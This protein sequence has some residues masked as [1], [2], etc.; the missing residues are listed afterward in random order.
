MYLVL[1]LCFF[2]SETGYLGVIVLGDS[3]AGHFRIP[4]QWL[5]SSMLDGEV[6]KNVEFIVAN[7]MDWPQ[8]SLYTAYLNES[9]SVSQLN[10]AQAV[11]FGRHSLGK[12]A[13]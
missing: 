9:R 7:E 8:L 3:V 13:A 12:N 10:V 5:T 4:P 11:Q 1:C 6:F 2:L